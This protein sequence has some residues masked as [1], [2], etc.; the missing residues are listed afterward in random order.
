MIPDYVSVFGHR[1]GLVVK[2][3]VEERPKWILLLLQL[4]KSGSMTVSEAKRAVKLGYRS[5][6]T[7]VYYLGGVSLGRGASQ[8][9][10]SHATPLGI[11]PVLQ[12]IRVPGN[13]KYLSLTDYGEQFASRLVGYLKDVAV[14]LGGVDVESEY[15]IPRVTLLSELSSRF[16]DVDHNRLLSRFV[17]FDTLVASLARV[18]PQLLA[19]MRPELIDAVPVELE[20]AVDRRTTKRLMLYLLL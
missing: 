20:I 18:N 17:S 4:R 1:E 14:R 9:V 15:G 10:A 16:P 6:R 8:A 5:L 11:P 19:V 13:K 7:A 12:V 3:L 2:T